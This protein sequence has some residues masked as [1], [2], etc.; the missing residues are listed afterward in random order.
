MVHTLIGG[1]EHEWIIFHFIC[2][3]SA[4]AFDSYLSENLNHQPDV[5]AV[6]F[7]TCLLM[8]YILHLCA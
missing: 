2:G 5:F 8:V 3:M 4:F 6:V 1:L 7:R